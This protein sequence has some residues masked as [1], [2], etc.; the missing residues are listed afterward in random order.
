[1]LSLAA[2]TLAQDALTEE[3]R[4]R[5]LVLYARGLHLLLSVGSPRQSVAPWAAAWEA[6][7]RELLTL[8]ALGH[9]R[10]SETV[11]LMTHHLFHPLSQVSGTEL[12]ALWPALSQRLA[13]GVQGM[14]WLTALLDPPWGGRQEPQRHCQLICLDAIPGQGRGGLTSLLP[15]GGQGW[16]RDLPPDLESCP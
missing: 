2:L 4:S 9:R 3:E 10:L 15:S 1:M 11:E 12:W 13:P 5:V 8:V 6:L 16:S 7:Y 14:V